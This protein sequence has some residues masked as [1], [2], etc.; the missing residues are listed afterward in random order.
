MNPLPAPPTVSPPFPY[1]VTPDAAN[2]PLS[3]GMK[4]AFHHW[5]ADR[6]EDNPLFTAFKYTPLEGFDYHGGDGTVSRRDASKI[7]FENGKFYVWYT[8]RQ[9]AAAPVGMGRAKEAT[10]TIPSADW[11]LAEVWYATSTDG[12]TWSEQGPAFPRPEK[13]TLGWR[14]TCTPDILKWEGRFYL[15]YQAFLE[16][17]G[18]RGDYCPVA[19]AHADSPDGP[20]ERVDQDVL[21]NGPEGS[22]DQFAI[23]DPHP[24]VHDGKVYIYY[25]SAYDRPNRLTLGLGLAIGDSPLGPFDKHPLNPLLNSGHET[26]LFPFKSGLAALMIRDGN[27]HY[28]IQ[29]AEDWVNFEMASIV[30]L[31][32]TAAGLF[33]P[34]AFEDSGNGPGVS[35][36]LCH[37]VNAGTPTTQHSILARFDCDLRQETADPAMKSSR[38]LHQPEVYFGMALSPAQ[39]QR[40]KADTASYRANH[41]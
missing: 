7:I 40:I 10:D 35:W 32:P 14:S 33:D 9:T 36:G 18:L 11:D 1:A 38:F 30:E 25:K 20:W 17:S 13:P 23:H 37:F 3:S 5:P 24:L 31:P 4:R 34:G 8:H 12:F 6:P 27:E 21:P 19:V 15:Y 2:R 28:T 26:A 29:Y 39:R 16:P 22:W 41:S